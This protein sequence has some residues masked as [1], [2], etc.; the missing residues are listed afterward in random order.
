MLE[1]DGEYSRKFL[2]KKRLSKYLS[3]AE[4]YLSRGEYPEFYR[5]LQK[6][7][8]Y[9]I[10]DKAGISRGLGIKAILQE[11]RAMSIDEKI[12]GR[13]EYIYEECNYSAYSGVKN[14]TNADNLLSEAKTIFDLY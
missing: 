7:V 6:G 12:I 13:I 14:A 2:A 10:T 1:T 3:E 8:F 4:T 11:L 9:Y 5:A